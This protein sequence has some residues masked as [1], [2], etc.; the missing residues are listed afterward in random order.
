MGTLLGGAMKQ[1][2]TPAEWER[3][4]ETQTERVKQ[5]QARGQL[6]AAETQGSLLARLL[7]ECRKWIAQKEGE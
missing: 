4:I 6:R 7:K 3:I 1:P 2:T 5:A